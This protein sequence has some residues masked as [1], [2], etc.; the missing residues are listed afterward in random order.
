MDEELKTL[1]ASLTGSAPEAALDDESRQT[2]VYAMLGLHS[3][4]HIVAIWKFAGSITDEFTR[5]HLLHKLVRLTAERAID[6]DLAEQIARSIPHPY[7]KFDS[8]NKIADELLKR[9]REVKHLN[10]KT[11][12]EI[13]DRG[14]R[15]LREVEAALPL[16]PEDDYAS[17][18]W[19]VGLSLV[20]AGKLEWAE[21][22]ASTAQYCPENTEILLRSGEARMALGQAAQAANLA[23]TVAELAGKSSDNA[24]NRGFDLI[25][26]SELAF[27][28]GERD[29]AISYLER[30]T[31][32]VEPM[33][34]HD[35]DGCKCLVA[36]AIAFAKQGCSDRARNVAQR[37]TQPA[38]RERALHEIAELA[39]LS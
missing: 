17:I 23:R 2:I 1:L 39:P 35:I 13:Q 30:A 37:V 9:S 33:Q 19:S 20:R 27:R 25:A 26:A 34:G 16:V 28:C 5:S 21:S 24:V 22:L 14:L 29:A 12:E 15:L 3:R 8:L 36:V 11:S 31:E 7:W 6:H 10:A 4:E 32:I 38:R 18:I